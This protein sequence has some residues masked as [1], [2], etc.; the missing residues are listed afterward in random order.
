MQLR[1][2]PRPTGD[3]GAD[4]RNALLLRI[5]NNFY[6]FEAPNKPR[7]TLNDAVKGDVN[8]FASVLYDAADEFCKP[9]EPYKNIIAQL[10]K[11]EE[12]VGKDKRFTMV[13]NGKELARVVGEGKQI[14]VF[15]GIEGG[16]AVEGPEHVPELASRGVAYV[17]LAHL[18]FRFVAECVNPFPCLD[19]ETYAWM[20]PQSSHGLTPLGNKICEALFKN[21]ILV[22]ITHCS[23]AA[24][25]DVFSIAAKYPHQPVISSHT[26]A[27]YLNGYLINISD[28][29]IKRVAATGGVIGVIFYDHWL[30][31]T[32]SKSESMD[33]LFPTIDH[34]HE[35][36]N[37]WDFIG[38]GSDLD[39]F[40][41]PVR[42]LKNLSKV[43]VLES[44]LV[45]K[46]GREAADKILYANALRVF[47]QGW[48]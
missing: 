45:K 26:A 44:A 46:Y 16:Y 21:R 41:R 1:F 2:P 32:G 5:A 4:R 35:K 3:L 30:R 34:I 17:I 36:T 10:E 33:L 22:D 23:D 13:P 7:V 18:F 11:V 25:D 27:R 42:E 48:G 15:H 28:E 38:I 29:S 14:A 6:N 20:F 37:S 8:G 12:K 47:E 39:G 31:P 19:D 9:H 43:K 24:I 40:I